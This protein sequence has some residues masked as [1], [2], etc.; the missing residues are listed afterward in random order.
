[1]NWEITVEEPVTLPH[2]DRNLRLSNDSYDKRFLLQEGSFSEGVWVGLVNVQL[3]DG[4]P[5]QVVRGILLY[6]IL[7]TKQSFSLMV[8]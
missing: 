2:W 4:T 3:K 7:L 6:K 1:M 5:R 8:L